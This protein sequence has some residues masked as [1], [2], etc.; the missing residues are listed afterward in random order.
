MEPGSWADW[1]SAGGSFAAAVIALW[2]SGQEKRRRIKAEHPT[3]SCNVEAAPQTPDEHWA[4]LSIRFRNTSGKTW[5]CYKATLASPSRG[6]IVRSRDTIIKTTGS[7]YGFDAANRATNA[8]RSIPLKIEL[9]PVGISRPTWNNGGGPGD[10]AQEMLQIK[11]HPG[12]PV[13]VRLSLKSL[14]PVPDHFEIMI[15]RDASDFPVVL[16]IA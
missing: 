5:L 8:K 12:K 4:A 13:H 6:V 15:K 1:A 10:F 16:P 7:T 3:I 2:L 11:M 14:E 9:L